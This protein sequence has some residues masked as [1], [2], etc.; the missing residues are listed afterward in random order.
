MLTSDRL[1]SSLPGLAQHSAG[2]RPTQANAVATKLWVWHQKN[3]RKKPSNR[4]VVFFLFICYIEIDLMEILYTFWRD[5]LLLELD[6]NYILF[7]LIMIQQVKMCWNRR[8]FCAHNTESG[9]THTHADIRIEA[10]WGC[11]H[12]LTPPLTWVAL[13]DIRMQLV[14]IRNLWVPKP[15]FL[16]WATAAVLL[17]LLFVCLVFFLTSLREYKFFS[18]KGWVFGGKVQIFFQKVPTN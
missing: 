17:L 6:F 10:A 12:I 9:S 16:W 7:I 13:A 4:M 11:L 5:R 2:L 18:T 3:R 14:L 15:K 1:L 8:N